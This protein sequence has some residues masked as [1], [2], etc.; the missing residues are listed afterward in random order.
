MKLS[1][2]NFWGETFMLIPNINFWS[3]DDPEYAPH[4]YMF[5][6]GWLWWGWRFYFGKSEEKEDGPIYEVRTIY[7]KFRNKTCYAIKRNHWCEFVGR[8]TLEMGYDIA[9]YKDNCW[10]F[11]GKNRIGLTED[12]RAAIRR[13]IELTEHEQILYEYPMLVWEDDR[14]ARLVCDLLIKEA[15][16]RNDDNWEI[17]NIPFPSHVLS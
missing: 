17:L 9:E 14:D 2:K 15:D 4:K 10:H 13:S 6:I 12:M 11:C 1:F 8:Y 3:D 16:A 7:N 5:F